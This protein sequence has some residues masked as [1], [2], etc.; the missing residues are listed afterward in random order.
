M[1]NSNKPKKNQ[2]GDKA[3]VS[4]MDVCQTPPHALEPLMPYIPKEWLVWESAVGPERM[5][6][7]TL[8]LN[9]YGVI[10]TDLMYGDEYNYFTYS[11]TDYDIEITNVPFSIKYD[12][13]STAFSR[14]KPFA[15]LVPYETTASKK[16]QDLFKAYNGKPWLIEKLVPERRINFKMPFAGWGLRVFDD[17]KGKFVKKGGSS[18]FSTMWLTWGL[19][20]S[21]KRNDYVREFYVPMRKISSEELE[22]L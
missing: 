17:V 4:N 11:P 19:N 13:L 8:R 21:G 1:A 22:R 18:Q 7:T 3:K 2:K 14:G 20:I 5:I 15:L 10:G 12:W 16:F 9:G 6:E